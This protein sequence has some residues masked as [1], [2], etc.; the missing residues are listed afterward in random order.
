MRLQLI[1]L[2]ISLFLSLAGCKY[3][4]PKSSNQEVARVGEQY[5][6]QSDIEQITFDL[7]PEDSLVVANNYIDNWIKEQLLLI[8]ALQNLSESQIDFEQQLEDYRNSLIIYAYENQLIKQ[9]LDT[10]VTDEQVLSYYNKNQLNF[11]LKHSLFRGRLVKCLVSA[12]NQDSLKFWL[13]KELPLF[14]S[15]LIEYCAQF[16]LSCDLDT[17]N[18][19]SDNSL[20]KLLPEGKD[21]EDVSIHTGNIEVIEDTLSRLYFDVWEI[22]QKG[23]KAPVAYVKEQIVEIIR[24]RRKLELISSVKNEI[25]EEATL[26]KKYEIYRKK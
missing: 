6:Y 18:W 8:K 3:F 21:V 15:K 12:P 9:K 23:E 11:E 7:S 13:E 19:I 1:V 22:K 14:D 25:F 2:T 4:Q 10:L 17:S 20:N 16:T 24:N 5:L 26:N